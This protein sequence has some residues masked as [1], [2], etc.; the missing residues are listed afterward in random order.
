MPGTVRTS[1]PLPYRAAVRRNSSPSRLRSVAS[2]P[3]TPLR[4][5]RQA[6]FTAGSMP[7]MGRSA[8][9]SRRKSMAAAV[10]VLQATTTILQ[11]IPTSRETAASASA[12]TSSRGREP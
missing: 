7:T 1:I 8:Y 10:A 9:F 6:G 3:T 2:T 5:A 4:V 12:R 11:P